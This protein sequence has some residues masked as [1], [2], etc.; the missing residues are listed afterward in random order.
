[1]GGIKINAFLKVIQNYYQY[2][3]VQKNASLLSKVSHLSHITHLPLSE[4]N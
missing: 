4:K 1:M 3:G 2:S